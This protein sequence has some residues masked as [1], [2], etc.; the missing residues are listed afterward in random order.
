MIQRWKCKDCKK[1]YWG[2]PWMLVGGGWTKCE[3]CE[4]ELEAYYVPRPPEK[5]WHS[6]KVI[7]TGGGRGDT[8]EEAKMGF[9]SYHYLDENDCEFLVEAETS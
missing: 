3:H 7:V 9:F 8:L 1:D 2:I 6:F 5:P 4:G